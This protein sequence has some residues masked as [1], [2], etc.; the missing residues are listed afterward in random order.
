MMA[1]PS[2]LAENATMITLNSILAERARINDERM[3]ST[4]VRRF[5]RFNWLRFRIP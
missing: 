5:G 4:L 2:T 3:L 1:R